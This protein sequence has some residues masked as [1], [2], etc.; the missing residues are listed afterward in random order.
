MGLQP[1]HELG[2]HYEWTD[3]GG[4][5]LVKA[6]YEECRCEADYC[7]QMALKA[8]TSEQKAA[9][10]RCAADWLWPQDSGAVTAVPD[11]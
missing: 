4:T 6:S 1:N 11:E 2:V 9:R 3:L 5:G 8:M 10:L 7:E